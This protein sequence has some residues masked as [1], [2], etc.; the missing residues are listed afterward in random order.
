MF[1]L[2]SKGFLHLRDQSFSDAELI[3]FARRFSSQRGSIE[4]ELLHWDFGPLM[5]MKFEMSAKNY[6]FSSEDVPFH[7]DGAFHREPRFLLFY[8]TQSSGRGGA[9]TFADTE[10][11][12]EMMSPSD[13]KEALKVQLTYRTEKKVHYGGEITVPLVQKHPVTG[14]TILRMAEAVKTK[15]NPVELV[16]HG[17][18]DPLGF[19][20]RMT[21]YLYEHA[22]EHKW[23]RGDLLLVDNYTYLHGRRPLE[24]NLSRSF[25]RIQIL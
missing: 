1:T 18:H 13:R 21:S 12:W 17:S 10:R 20:E 3:S 25:K 19:Y 14:A 9:T 24:E 4:E 23:E 15:L 8:C 11:I 6:L 7:W 5:E 22:F 16:I 2:K